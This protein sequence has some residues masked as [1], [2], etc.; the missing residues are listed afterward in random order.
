MS[1]Y[2]SKDTCSRTRDK[3]MNRVVQMDVVEGLDCVEFSEFLVKEG[4]HE[5]VVSAFSSNRICGL[6]F[7]QLTEDDLKEM[8]PVIGDRVRIRKLLS[9]IRKVGLRKAELREAL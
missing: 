5:D 7:V 3:V 1:N 2:L 9:E 8:L 6:T 4:F